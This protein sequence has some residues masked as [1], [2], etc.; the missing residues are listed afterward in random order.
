MNWRVILSTIVIVGVLAGLA[1]AAGRWQNRNR[2]TVTGS[3]D[4]QTASVGGTATTGVCPGAPQ[5]RGWHGGGGNGYCWGAGRGNGRGAGICQ[6]LRLR[7]GTGMNC[8]LQRGR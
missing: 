1:T 7:D 2:A 3:T 6:R 5:G 4:N 8:P